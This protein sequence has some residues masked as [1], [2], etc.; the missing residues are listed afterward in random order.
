MVSIDTSLVVQIVNFLFLIWALNRVLYKPIRS[1]LVQRRQKA[2]GLEE[3]ASR[4]EQE[5]Q[6]K[7]LAL[8]AGLRQ[9]REK[10]LAEQAVF[11]QEARDQEKKLIE[12][13]NEKARTDLAQIRDRVAQETEAA[14]AALLQEIDS[15]ADDISRKIL[16]RAV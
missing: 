12:K 5:A 9:A 6:E 1:I 16:G 7:D 11:E 8:T 10:G 15:I 14:R 4:F 3:G 13:I 2:L